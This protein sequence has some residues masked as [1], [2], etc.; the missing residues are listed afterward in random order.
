MS[1]DDTELLA[2]TLARLAHEHDGDAL[3]AAL[4]RFGWPEALQSDP[5]VAIPPLFEAQ[6]RSGSWSSALHDVMTA[7]VSDIDPTT[8]IDTAA[9]V[10]PAPG[11]AAAGFV[12]DDS[13]VEL[14]GLLLG[15][16]PTPW[17]IMTI[18][19]AG[20]ATRLVRLARDAVRLE[21][22]HGLDP[23]LGIARVRASTAH[24]SV[25]IAEGTTATLWWTR[26]IA[27]GRRALSHQLCGVMSTMLDL[28]R[29]HAMERRQFGRP[30][31][32]FQA[33]RHRLADAHVNLAGAE[34]TINAVWKSDD[35]PLASIIGKLVCG[36]AALAVAAHAQ[37]VLAGVGFTA[38]HPFHRGMKR[39][40]V[41]D[42]VLGSADELAVLAGRDLI[43]RGCAPRLVEL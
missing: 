20:G 12:H 25:C 28:A 22:Q 15:A 26:S 36:R 43:T 18:V 10:L 17:L 11:R 9:V 24:P 2:A 29:T 23:A 32:A 5:Q 40:I 1:D 4:D 19:D 30:V 33:V 13:Q 42:R 35:D 38:E 31:G 41:L 14:D 7:G 34:A 3:T 37:Q 16:R 8:T 27:L 21:Q 39:A 6:G